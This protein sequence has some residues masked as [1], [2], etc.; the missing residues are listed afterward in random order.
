MNLHTF[1]P[2]HYPPKLGET[3]DRNPIRKRFQPPN[4]YDTYKSKAS[5]I[6]LDQYEVD[7]K[8]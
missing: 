1:R 8:V 6:N 4:A 5:N 3:A 7:Q 2:K